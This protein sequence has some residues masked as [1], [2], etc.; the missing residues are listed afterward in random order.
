MDVLKSYAHQV[1]SYHP[2]KARDDLFAEIYDELCEE[3]KDWQKMNPGKSEA[4]FLDATRD[5][6]MKY[7]TRL[8]AEDSAYLVGPQFYF[9]F[10]SALKIGAAL[11]ACFYLFLATL[12]ALASGLDLG[13]FLG[14]L[15]GI[16]VSL[17]WVSA[18]I[19]GVF[20]ALEKSGERASWLDNWSAADLEP[21]DDHKQMSRGETLFDLGVAVLALLWLVDIIHV[22]AVIDLDGKSVSDW[23]VNVPDGF[24][25]AAGVLLVFDIAY[26]LYRL[27]RSFWSPRLRLTSIAS[28]LLWLALLGFA[29]AQPDLL[30]IRGEPTAVQQDVLQIANRAAKGSLAVVCAI[31]AWDTV[32]HIWKLRR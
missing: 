6:P 3:F 18:S 16:P 1:V 2:E 27:T 30:S 10:L 25:I 28:N 14:V 5:H 20:I 23:L 19:L 9:S 12:S 31:L 26:A 13:A 24:W 21:I 32:T 4:S 17:L 8:A 15:S 22:P 29:I 7:A 11:T